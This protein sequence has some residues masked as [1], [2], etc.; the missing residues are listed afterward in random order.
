MI[1]RT[2]PKLE[3]NILTIFLLNKNDSITIT[4]N[5]GNQNPYGWLQIFDLSFI[6]EL[7]HENNWMPHKFQ[8]PQV[9]IERV[10]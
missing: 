2:G 8:M 4:T 9:Y 10:V 1:A 6:I 5:I 3:I 7:G